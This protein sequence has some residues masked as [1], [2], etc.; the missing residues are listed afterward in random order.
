MKKLVRQIAKLKTPNS[1]TSLTP[2][3][4]RGGIQFIYQLALLLLY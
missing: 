2:T 1:A 3:N 4:S